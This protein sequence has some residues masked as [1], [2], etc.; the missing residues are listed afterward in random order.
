MIE[1][2]KYWIERKE[3]TKLRDNNFFINMCTSK[4]NIFP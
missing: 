2:E 4:E 1:Y 3:I